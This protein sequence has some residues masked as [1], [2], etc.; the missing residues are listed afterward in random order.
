V[1]WI[2]VLTGILP[3]FIPLF[4]FIG[5]LLW[6]TYS[7]HFGS[8]PTTCAMND[9]L[10]I[11]GKEFSGSGT[12]VVAELNCKL[13][14]RDSKLS[15]DVVLESKGNLELT[16]ENSTLEGRDV[17]LK[18]ENN[19]NVSI[20]GGSVV[21]SPETAVAGTTNVEIKVDAASIEGGSH[22]VDLGVN[23]KVTLV[24]KAKVTSAGPAIT[25]EMNLEASFDDS[26]VDSKDIAIGGGANTKLK[27]TRGSKVHGARMAIRAAAN[28]RL[29]LESSTVTSEGTALCAGYNTE[30]TG[31]HAT[32]SGAVEALRLQHK[33]NEFDLTDSAVHGAEVFDAEG[34]GSASVATPPFDRTTPPS[35]RSR[36]K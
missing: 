25:G 34:C 33:P 14:I 5:P 18:L 19:S 8:M 4:I 26:S 35:A 29:A 27:L 32:L 7:T 20:A 23:G 6:K 30:I 10:E 17:A 2:I 21:R 15:G 13:K 16:I 31:S 28:T 3:A 12:V 11:V 1:I 24:H 9:E 22:G 36:A